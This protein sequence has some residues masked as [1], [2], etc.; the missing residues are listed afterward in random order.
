M[1]EKRLIEII[2][3]MELLTEL[4]NKEKI[5]GFFSDGNC[6]HCKEMKPIITNIS[7]SDLVKELD[8]YVC[9]INASIP[10][11]LNYVGQVS[12][13]MILPTSIRFLNGVAIEGFA[14][15]QPETKIIETLEKPWENIYNL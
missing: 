8:I 4:K 5:F 14:G 15:F 3:G 10:A 6:P 12:D 2:N 7:Q 9:I 11:A 13:K 1:S